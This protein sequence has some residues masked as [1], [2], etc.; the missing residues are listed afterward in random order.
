MPVR[1]WNTVTGTNC[2]FLLDIMPVGYIVPVG[3]KKRN[4]ALCVWCYAHGAVRMVLC[5]WRCAFVTAMGIM[6]L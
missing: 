4:M 5:T 2:A 1:V 3:R 6:S